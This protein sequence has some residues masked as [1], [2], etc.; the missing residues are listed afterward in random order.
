MV[1]TGPSGSAKWK[2]YSVGNIFGDMSTGSK[3]LAGG[4][5]NSEEEEFQEKVD[6]AHILITV[7]ISKTQMY[8]VT[9]CETAAESWKRS[10]LTLSAT[11]GRT[12]C[13][14]CGNCSS[15]RDGRRRVPRRTLPGTEGD[16][17]STGSDG[18]TGQRKVSG[19]S[20]AGKSAKKLWHCCVQSACVQTTV[21]PYPSFKNLF[22]M[23]R[24]E[25]EVF[26]SSS[27][28]HGQP[29]SLGGAAYFVTF[30]DDF[31]RCSAVYFM[32]SKAE[33]LEKFKEFEAVITNMS[34]K[35]IGT[36]RI[37]NGGECIDVRWIPDIFEEEWHM[38]WDHCSPHPW[39]E[40]CCW[41][42]EPYP[43]GE[44]KGNASARRA[45]PKRYWAEAV[46]NASYLRNRTPT[47][48]TY[49]VTWPLASLC[50]RHPPSVIR[51][52]SS[53]IP[54]SAGGVSP[55]VHQHY[56]H[57]FFWMCTTWCAHAAWF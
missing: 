47:R 15:Y 48:S 21:R 4:A 51:Y 36:L 14:W 53:I 12:P 49:S 39:T 22:W 24:W 26:M 25:E 18:G 50:V 33:V 20:L 29:R 46:A 27:V 9:L 19:R 8:L 17:R 44:G 42:D 6:E 30:I 32:K 43:D 13:F 10:L 31:T 40:W 28:V 35:K 54:R 38:T 45:I 3:T 55:C 2:S 57:A 5:S 11:P 56:I 16:D 41:K 34:G 1:K 7:A 23:R 37:D 52:P